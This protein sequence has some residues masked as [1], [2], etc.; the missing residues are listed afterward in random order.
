MDA[1]EFECCVPPP[2][3]GRP[4][5]WTLAFVT[6]GP[7]LSER[8]RWVRRQ[9]GTDVVV[10]GSAV[11]AWS[12]GNGPVPPPGPL[13]VPGALHGTAHGDG[14]LLT[15]FVHRVRVV[16]ERFV[17]VQE[18]RRPAWERV[19]DSTTLV[20]VPE[21]PLA[22]A[23]DGDQWETGLLLD[24]HVTTPTGPQGPASGRPSG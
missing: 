18:G 15:G 17:P 4:S 23:H 9:D 20:D 13:R 3:P 14:P 10:D 6:S 21:G 8:D 24:L 11:A 19:P 5:T 2:E 1:W 12:P 16:R 22:F 7:V